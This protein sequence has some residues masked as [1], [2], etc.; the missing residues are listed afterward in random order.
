MELTWSASEPEELF[1][2]FEAIGDGSLLFP[3]LLHRS[4]LPSFLHRKLRANSVTHGSKLWRKA[5][6]G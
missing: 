6:P 4:D 3:E 2:P 5:W 1:Q